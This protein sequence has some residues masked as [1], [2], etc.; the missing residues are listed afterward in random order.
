V[1]LAPVRIRIIADGFAAFIAEAE[2]LKRSMDQFA[3]LMP[4]IGGTYLYCMQPEDGEST[5]P[6]RAKIFLYGYRKYRRH[7]RRHHGSAIDEFITQ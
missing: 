4:K 2:R 1:S 6:F 5:C 3:A 7:Y